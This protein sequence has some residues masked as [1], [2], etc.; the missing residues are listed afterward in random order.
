MPEAV[1]EEAGEKEKGRQ[2]HQ[3][4]QCNGS[5]WCQA[6]VWTCGESSSIQFVHEVK[7]QPKT[8]FKHSLAIP[9]VK[10]DGERQWEHIPAW[11]TQAA[12]PADLCLGSD[13]KVRHTEPSPS[14]LPK[15]G[16]SCWQ[17]TLSQIVLHR[18]REAGAHHG[19]YGDLRSSKTLCAIGQGI[20]MFHGTSSIPPKPSHSC[21]SR[22]LPHLLPTLWGVFWSTPRGAL[23]FLPHSRAGAELHTDPA[24]GC[25][26]V[27][28]GSHLE[29]GVGSCRWWGTPE[30]FSSGR[31]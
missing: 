20:W 22:C 9:W 24:P 8:H 25:L 21:S 31:G 23:Q 15:A 12:L 29:K 5:G 14:E 16:T 11:C 18:D 26:W 27:E 3:D 10:W 19:G 17:G 28:P 30:G 4:P 2:G 13:V 1:V 7:I 6:A